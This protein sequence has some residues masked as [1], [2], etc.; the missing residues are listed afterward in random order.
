MPD[1]ND[2]PLPP[3]KLPPELLARMLQTLPTHDPQVRLGPGIGLDCAVID[4]GST[5]WVLKSDPITFATEEIG[6]YLVQVNAND[7]ATT[8]ARPRWL[9]AT[10]LLP[11]KGASAALVEKLAGQLARACDALGITVIGGHTEITTGLNRPLAMGTLIGE[12]SPER[13][14]TPQGIRPGDRILLTKG[15]PIEATAILAR[16]RPEQLSGVLSQSEIEEA[17]GFL[18]HPGISVLRDAQIAVSAGQVTA[19]HDPTEGGVATA[20]WE[21]AEAGGCT[22]RV[23]PAAIPIPPLARKVCRAFG[24]DP[25]GAIASGAL[26]LTAPPADSQSIIQAL[27][28]EGIP[29]T[30]IGWVEPGPAQVLVAATGQPLPR[31]ARDEIARVFEAGSG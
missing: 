15:A 13:L 19:M 18:V 21:L 31:P 29:C 2:E 3:G 11:E 1:F 6:W 20:L 28:A 17:Q 12:V 25:L 4:M 22:L 10:F 5:L 8:G 7:I 30:E 23:D 9:M 27:G 26:L 14:V 16:E 24:I